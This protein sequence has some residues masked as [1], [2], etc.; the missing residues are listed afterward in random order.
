MQHADL[1][2]AL[3]VRFDDRV[4]GNVSMFVPAANSAAK[5]GRGGIIHFDISPKNINKTVEATEAV[6]G[7]C[8][9]NLRQLIPLLDIVTDRSSWLG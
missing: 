6:V 3:G 1:I 2:I 9:T 4:T 7:D 5:A 8:T